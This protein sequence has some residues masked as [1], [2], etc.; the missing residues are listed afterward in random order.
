MNLI[1]DLQ[2]ICETV[3]GVFSALGR[4]FS[5]AV[6]AVKC[7]IVAVFACVVACLIYDTAMAHNIPILEAIGV[8]LLVV[9]TMFC[10][11][12]VFAEFAPSAEDIRRAQEKIDENNKWAT[13]EEQRRKLSQNWK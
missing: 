10:I 12:A 13:A 4:V 2:D 11:I 5:L 6:M 3:S 9:P 8:L 7:S 1:P